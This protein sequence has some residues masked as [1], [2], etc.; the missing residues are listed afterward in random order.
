MVSITACG[1]VGRGSNSPRGDFFSNFSFFLNN[2]LF[3]INS[4]CTSLV[5]FVE[6]ELGFFQGLIK[7]KLHRGKCN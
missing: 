1:K 3:I 4:P 2:R 7:K 6:F 5:E